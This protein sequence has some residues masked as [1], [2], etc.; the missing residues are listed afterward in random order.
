MIYD[1]IKNYHKSNNQST[2]SSS[3]TV[4]KTNHQ[5]HL[6]G[7]HYHNNLTPSIPSP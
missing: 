7:N 1:K 4:N 6:V 2:T 5:L 3:N